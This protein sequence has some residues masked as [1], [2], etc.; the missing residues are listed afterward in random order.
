MASRTSQRRSPLVPAPANEGAGGVVERGEAVQDG[1]VQPDLR[2][3]TPTGDDEAQDGHHAG[4][5]RKHSE[6]AAGDDKRT[7]NI[8]HVD[9]VEDHPSA[10]AS[11]P[12]Q[13][14]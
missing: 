14:K 5:K 1:Y 3:R 9:Q 6:A 10:G 7:E 8:I 4:D 13:A 2:G 12:R 11:A